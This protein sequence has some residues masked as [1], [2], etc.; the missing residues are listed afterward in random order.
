MQ[1]QYNPMTG[2]MGETWPI[3]SQL[4]QLFTIRTLTTDWITSTKTSMC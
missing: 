3:L 4:E 1:G 2:Q